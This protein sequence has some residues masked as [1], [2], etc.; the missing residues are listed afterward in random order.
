MR[1][2]TIEPERYRLSEQKRKQK[3]DSQTKQN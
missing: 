2:E 3:H 1:K